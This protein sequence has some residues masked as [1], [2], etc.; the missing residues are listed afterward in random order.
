[1]AVVKELCLTGVPHAGE[2]AKADYAG[3]GVWNLKAAAEARK[4]GEV[5]TPAGSTANGEGAYPPVE[6]WCAILSLPWSFCGLSFTHCAMQ[7]LYITLMYGRLQ[8][9]VCSAMQ[10]LSV[11]DSATRGESSSCSRMPKQQANAG[12]IQSETKLSHCRGLSDDA[13]YVHICG[14]ETMS[15]MT[16][17][18]EPEVGPNRV[19]VADMTSSLLSRPVDVSKY[20]VIYASSGKNLGPAGNCVVIVRDDLIGNELPQVC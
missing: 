13:A 6:E 10:P 19:L 12:Q 9:A 1:V 7:L 5:H 18:T 15:G 4:F 14:N 16:F 11:I 17:H 2:N 8:L 3:Q 20:G